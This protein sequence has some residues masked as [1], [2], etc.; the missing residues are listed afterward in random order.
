MQ[1][2]L[3]Y[4]F[5]SG[6]FSKDQS[7]VLKTWLETCITMTYI[8]QDKGIS[9]FRIG[10]IRRYISKRAY[11]A[12]ISPNTMLSMGRLIDNRPVRRPIRK[13]NI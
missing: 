4:R 12:K 10:V 6:R 7:A 8:S 2:M 1:G 13:L 3:V 5:Q 9:V 11:I